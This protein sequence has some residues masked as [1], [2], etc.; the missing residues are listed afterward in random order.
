MSGTKHDTGKLRM[1]LLS[2]PALQARAEALAFG[3]EK[4]GDFNW[5]KGFNW[6]RL[7]GAALRHLL[8]HMNGED[9][10]PESG[11]SHLAH[12]DCCIMFLLEHEIKG[13]GTDDRY[14]TGRPAQQTLQY[15]IGGNWYDSQ[16]A[17][18]YIHHM[19]SG[20]NL[21]VSGSLPVALR[22]Y[23]YFYNKDTA[24]ETRYV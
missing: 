10:D 2:V 16:N 6:S 18:K 7:Y 13:L 15:R 14:H 24:L 5:R 9:K 23:E 1:D 11:L 8:A 21:T 17:L 22:W 20:C 3:A 12:A 19:Q 4:Y